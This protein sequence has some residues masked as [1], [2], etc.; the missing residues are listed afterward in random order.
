MCIHITISN[1]INLVSF[2][3]G[4]SFKSFIIPMDVLTLY[5]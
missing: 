1:D 5:E 2:F 4:S 3:T